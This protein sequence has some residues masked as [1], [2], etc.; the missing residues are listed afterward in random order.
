MRL[1]K[2]NNIL[3]WLGLIGSQ[4]AQAFQYSDYVP[5]FGFSG[6]T[7]N[8][9]MVPGFGSGMFA[10]RIPQS[11]LYLGYDLGEYFS[12]DLGNQFSPTI[13]RTATSRRS[14]MFLGRMLPANFDYITE[15]R[16]KFNGTYL[17]LTAKVP[18]MYN[19]AQLALTIGANALK[20]TTKVTII[21][22]QTGL[23]PQNSN[24]R[25]TEYFASRRV[26]PQFAAGLTINLNQNFKLQLSSIYQITS[27]LKNLTPD[28]AG[29]NQLF[30]IS[31][32]NSVIYSLGI[33]Y[34]FD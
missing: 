26:I 15:N 3:F 5:N 24:L 4:G 27:R 17:N 2:A 13:T 21:G 11:N 7:R 31:F 12:V 6:E 8:L 14:E 20:A 32:K 9:D 30:R 16:I 25:V 23:Y 22:N 33:R 34:Q 29:V 19:Q 18:L 1:A 28:K 10:K